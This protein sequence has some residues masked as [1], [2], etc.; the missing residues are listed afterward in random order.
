MTTNLLSEELFYSAADTHFISKTEIV[1]HECKNTPTDL[2][3]GI[4]NLAVVRVGN[5]WKT[6]FMTQHISCVA[7]YFGAHSL[8]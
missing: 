1:L 5:K 7:K 3:K 2:H 8:S 6:F 4:T